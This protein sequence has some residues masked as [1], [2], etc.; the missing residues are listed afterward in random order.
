MVESATGL[1]LS[2]GV[3]L[4]LQAR[5]RLHISMSLLLGFML[6]RQDIKL[7]RTMLVE[8][9]NRTDTNRRD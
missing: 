4:S 9:I 8:I 2:K 3:L 7:L 6:E 1:F 5:V